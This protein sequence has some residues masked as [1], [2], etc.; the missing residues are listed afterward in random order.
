MPLKTTLSPNGMLLGGRVFAFA[1][2]LAEV[3]HADI[4][5]LVRHQR[6]AGQNGIRHMD[7]GAVILVDDEPVSPQLADASGYSGGLRGYHSAQG[8]IAQLL[9]VALERLQDQHAFHLRNVVRGV[10][11]MMTVGLELVVIPRCRRLDHEG[12]F[13]YELLGRLRLVSVLRGAI[14]DVTAAGI[15]KS[16]MRFGNADDIGSHVVGHGLDVARHRR[17]VI[18]GD[19]VRV[20]LA[21]AIPVDH[22]GEELPAIGEMIRRRHP[23]KRIFGDGVTV[24]VEERL[25]QLAARVF[26]M[27]RLVHV[28]V[29]MRADDAHRSTQVRWRREV[30]LRGIVRCAVI[31]VQWFRCLFQGQGHSDF[32]LPSLQAVGKAFTAWSLTALNETLS[33]PSFY[34]CLTTQKPASVQLIYR[35]PP[36]SF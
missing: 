23:R 31:P 15:Q 35:A 26:W 5:G 28:D 7:T 9:D 6:Q 29:D 16:R 22:R 11:D 14:L 17:G 33:V 13:L 34:V 10:A 1:A 25:A 24:P 32:S 8:G 30:R 21:F 19:P 3:I 2:Y 27:G 4:N 12:K 20:D 36:A 18:H